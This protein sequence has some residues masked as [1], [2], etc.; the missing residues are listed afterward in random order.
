MEREKTEAF[1]RLLEKVKGWIINVGTIL[2]AVVV[3][4]EEAEKL[5]LTGPDRKVWVIDAIRRMVLG[6]AHIS[7]EDKD[8]IMTFIDVQLPILIEII[9][10]GTKGLLA[11][12]QLAGQVVEKQCPNCA[13]CKCINGC[14]CC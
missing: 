2:N 1:T 7:L 13:N 4:M 3:A 8:K 9:I 12:N 14:L 11:I 10:Q 6:S 5:P